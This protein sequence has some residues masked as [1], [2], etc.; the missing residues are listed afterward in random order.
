MEKM[1]LKWTISNSY[2]RFH[3]LVIVCLAVCFLGAL[4]AR[5]DLIISV[6]SVSVDAGTTGNS[7]DVDL[8]NTGPAV[9]PIGGFTFG[10]SIANPNVSF[11]D[12]NTST[13]AFYIF[14]GH[15]LFGPDLTGATSG[16][17]LHTSDV[18]DT[19]NNGVAIDS[20]ATVGIGHILFDVLPGASPGPFAVNL[21][22]PFTSLSDFSGNVTRI[23]TLAAGQITIEGV[24]AIPEP[25]TLG[26][27]LAGVMMIA[28]AHRLRRKV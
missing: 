3:R 1:M 25:G 11:T 13:S 17:S 12:A 8:T 21:S 24:G 14:T 9:A 16:Q 4:S 6:G 27:L 22:A 5:A 28:G 15:S 20:G 23:E 18:F 10:I 26:L 7:F 19:P 2:A